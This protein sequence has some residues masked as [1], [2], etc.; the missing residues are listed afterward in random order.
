MKNLSR[1]TEFGYQRAKNVERPNLVNSGQKL[2]KDRI[3][4]T[5][6]KK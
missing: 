6:D 5:A 4:L 3:W 1:K 2:W